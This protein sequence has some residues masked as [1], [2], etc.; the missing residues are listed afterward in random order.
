[1]LEFHVMGPNFSCV[2]ATNHADESLCGATQV[3]TSNYDASQ[4][5]KKHGFCYA[6]F[7]KASL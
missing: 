4:G 6:I 1:M 2:T 5:S 7:Y 3:P